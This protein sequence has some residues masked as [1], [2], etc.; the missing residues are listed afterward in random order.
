MLGEQQRKTLFYT[1]DVLRQLCA[2]KYRKREL[3]N[4]NAK[5]ATAISLIERDF[6]V[7]IMNITT[8]LI[9]HITQGIME[10]GPL[11]GTWM[12]AYER[13]YSWMSQRIVNRR[14]IES[15]VM[16]TFQIFDWCMHQIMA[17]KVRLDERQKKRIQKSLH[18]ILSDSEAQ[19]ESEEDRGD[20]HMEV[21][22]EVAREIER[23]GNVNVVNKNCKVKNHV[24]K[25]NT[26]T[27]REVRYSS[28]QGE[29]SSSKTAS[30]VVYLRDQRTFGRINR[31]V[32]VQEE[33][34]TKEETWALIR[35]YEECGFDRDSQCFVA[36][37]ELSDSLVPV[38]L[39][40]LEDPLIFA[41]M[42]NQIWFINVDIE[43]EFINEDEL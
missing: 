41:V 37:H 31:F 39:D 9:I 26:E 40:N 6:P 28:Q 23:Q 14:H 34:E 18:N 3:L 1:A 25:T 17:S 33:N 21:P 29:R 2:E 27:K 10:Y 15:T 36:K 19:N 5:A 4:L 35:K 42:D 43:R 38:H 22:A 30:S 16:R 11:Y 24:T 8:H 7:Y 20:M 32:I 13:F 12:F